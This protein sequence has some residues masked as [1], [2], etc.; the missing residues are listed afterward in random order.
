MVLEENTIYDWI[1]FLGVAFYLISYTLLQMGLI[2]GSGYAYALMNLSAATLVL[3]SLS[4]KF[5]LSAAIIQIMWIVIS[6]FG[7]A[8][9]Y[10]I[11]KRIRFSDEELVL[12]AE[13]LP[14]MPKP[15]AR[16]FLDRGIWSHAEAGTELTREG[17]FVSHLHFLENG[18]AGVISA[19]QRVATLDRGLIGEM[20]VMEPGPASASVVIEKPGRI[21]TVS[22]EVLRKM[23]A[24]DTEFRAYLEAAL[25]QATRSKLIEANRQL[26]Q[27][28]G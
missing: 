10:W 7:I 6:T 23:S 19:G 17:E 13:A 2:R 11:S 3:V 22:G 21:F 4:V 20:N 14:Q 24:A 12:I 26:S 27:T 9:I 18:R 16:K 15:F 5:N 8:R 25:S 28:S 1:G